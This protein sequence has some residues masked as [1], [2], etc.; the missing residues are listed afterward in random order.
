MEDVKMA[1]SPFSFFT[2][3]LFTRRVNLT[4][5]Y[6]IFITLTLTL[7]RT[8]WEKRHVDNCGSYEKNI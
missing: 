5:I 1:N 6:K 2:F 7:I 3:P 8:G 4:R